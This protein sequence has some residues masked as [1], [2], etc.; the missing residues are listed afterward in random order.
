MA[1]EE[2]P[3]PE[4]RDPRLW[5]RLDAL[6]SEALTLSEPERERWLSEL[7]EEDQPLA[8]S[9]REML[10]RTLSTG[11]LR[12][13][14]SAEVLAAAGEQALEQPGARV[15]PYRL[16]RRLGVGGMG[17][18]W[19]AER[20]DG[21]IQRQV[22]LKLPRTG[23]AP[24]MAER[25]KQERDALAA[26]EHPS[27]ARLYDAGTTEEGR[28]Y[29]AME[30][31]DGVPIDAYARAHGLTLRERLSLFLQV[32]GAVSYAHAHLVVHRDLKPS[33]ILVSETQGVRLLDF[34]AAKLLQEEGPGGDSELTRELGPALSPDYASPEQIRGERVSVATDVYSLG[35]RPLRVGDGPASVPVVPRVVGGAGGVGGTA[36]GAGGQQPCPGRREAGAGAAGRPGRGAGEGD[37]TRSRGAVRDGA[38]V[39]RRRVALRGRGASAGEAP[40][41]A[42]A[43][44]EVRPPARAGGRDGGGGDAAG[45]WGRRGG[46]VAGE[47]GPG[48]GAAGRTGAAIHRLHPH[49]CH[50]QDGGGRGGDGVGPPHR[51][52]WPHREGAGRRT[53]HRRRAR[54][55]G[56]PEL[57]QPRRDLHGRARAPSGGS[58]RR[59]QHSVLPT[60]SRS[61][62]ERS[63]RTRSSS[64][65]SPRRWRSSTRWFPRRSGGCPRPPSR[66]WKP[67]R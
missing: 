57:R 67:S 33:N 11:F 52:C 43:R 12:D 40:E 30:Y 16:L 17:Q 38:G 45:G 65:T 25:L 36:G 15:G 39:C 64:T 49:Q 2:K 44:L 63:L 6:L 4:D 19:L 22:A 1:V 28:P 53:S 7:P 3:A 48:R 61:G 14:V 41:R 10:S 9:L 54:V 50:A 13:P 47:G 5:Q 29:I 8:S 18:V 51:G 32:A 34:G 37:A 46:A 20:V 26:L 31:V 59:G 21:T 35:R 66:R 62:R 27:I 24:G 42:R 23:W 60:R 58:T 55:S 56:R